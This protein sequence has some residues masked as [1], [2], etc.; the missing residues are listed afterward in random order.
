MTY[1]LVNLFN[2]KAGNVQDYRGQHEV[3]YESYPSKNVKRVV[4]IPV[5]Y[6]M[7]PNIILTLKCSF[8]VLSFAR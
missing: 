6:K 7:F 5:S 4:K 2:F 3:T 1:I 8:P